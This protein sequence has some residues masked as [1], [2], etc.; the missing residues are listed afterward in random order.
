MSS[1]AT[2]AWSRMPTAVRPVPI[3][4]TATA[5]GMPSGTS[6][7][8]ATAASACSAYPPLARPRCATTRLVS[9]DGS[10]PAP[11]A[12]MR[13]ATSRPGVIGSCN[14]W[15]TALVKPVRSEVSR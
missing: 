3:D 6:W 2:G 11:I 5:H 1:A 12:S 14:G 9:H 7:R 8:L 15:C 13:P 4:A 10:T